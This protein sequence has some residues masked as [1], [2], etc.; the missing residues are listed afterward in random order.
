MDQGRRM[1][2]DEQRL[3]A[4]LKIYHPGKE[5]LCELRQDFPVA[6]VVRILTVAYYVE[7]WIVSSRMEKRRPTI[8]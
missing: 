7:Q 3:D 2:R 6:S 4:L 5:I 1:H 8:Q